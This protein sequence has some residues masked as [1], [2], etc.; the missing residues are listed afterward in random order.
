MDVSIKFVESFSVFVIALKIDKI[1]II[2][3]IV[4]VEKPSENFF[5]FGLSQSQVP[6]T[7]ECNVD[8]QCNDQAYENKLQLE[9]IKCSTTCHV[10]VLVIGHW[11]TRVNYELVCPL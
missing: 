4:A 8:V 5:G 10:G 7:I 3:F 6:M 11:G 1:K 9:L 2:F